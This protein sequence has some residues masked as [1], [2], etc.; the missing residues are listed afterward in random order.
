VPLQF[1]PFF[2]VRFSYLPE[3]AER[4]GFLPLRKN[5]FADKK[6]RVQTRARR[7]VAG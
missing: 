4:A 7:I 5:L 3:A 2:W 6:G 1:R